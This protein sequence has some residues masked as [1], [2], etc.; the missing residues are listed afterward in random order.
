MWSLVRECSITDGLV[1][2]IAFLFFIFENALI[3][4]KNKDL[5]GRAA[6]IKS[7]DL[8]LLPITIRLHLTRRVIICAA[9]CQKTIFYD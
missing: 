6:P 4:Q 7:S 1:K 8:L 3:D 2:I 5:N 9:V